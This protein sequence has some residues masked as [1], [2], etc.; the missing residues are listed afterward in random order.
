[1]KKFGV[2]EEMRPQF[3]KQF[4]KIC[5][6]ETVFVLSE[7]KHSFIGEGSDHYGFPTEKR[8][9]EFESNWVC[10]T[11]N[12]IYEEPPDTSPAC[13]QCK[14]QKF[15]YYKERNVGDPTFNSDI[16][17]CQDCQKDFIVKKGAMKSECE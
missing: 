15:F 9:T 3:K 2:D 1:M 11:C 4:C 13:P 6:K 10:Q 12:R 8:E 5:Q 7:H 14:S 16:Y 17:H